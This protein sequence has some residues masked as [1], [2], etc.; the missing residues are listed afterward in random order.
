MGRPIKYSTTKLTG[1]LKKGN[2]I[3][4]MDKDN[5]DL[6][7][8]NSISP[9]HGYYVVYEAVPGGSPRMYVPQNASELIR[10][11]V[12]KGGVAVSTE[13]DALEWL[14]S[15]GYTTK[16]KNLDIN[17]TD[18]LVLYY[19]PSDVSSYP[20]K[21]S[22]IYDLSGNGNN[23]SLYNGITMSSGLI[24]LDG[25]NDYISIPFNSSMSGW[26]SGQTIL[27]WLK[28]NISSGRRNPWNQAYGGY[29]TWTHEQG[30][31][32][33]QY[34]GDAGANASPYIG[35]SSPT[36]P[37]NTWN[38]VA[39]TRDTLTHSW[40]LN[41]NLSSSRGHSYGVL[42][43][44]TNQVLIG[45]GYA[46]YW[47]GQMGPI[48]AYDRALTQDEIKSVWFNGNIVTDGLVLAIDPSSLGSYEQGS[49]TTN[50]L[51]NPLSGTLLNGMGYST[52]NGGTFVFD[53]I[54]DNIQVD[55]QS[56]LGTFSDWSVDAWVKWSDIGYKSWMIVTDQAQYSKFY[57]N[58]MVWLSSDSVNKRIA[59]YDGG[60]KYSVGNIPSNT[61]THIAA[62]TE[63]LVGKM[64]INGVLD[65]VNTFTWTDLTNTANYLGIGGHAGNSGYRFNGNIGPVRTYSRTLTDDEVMQNYNAQKYRFTN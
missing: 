34:F 51:V 57:K 48:T 31:N 59:M 26:N 15:N 61:W 32:I 33:S 30:G 56:I 28:H 11:A 54:N 24:N 1:T 6:T 35:V 49:L 27:M 58:T 17:I 37:K 23:G 45:N 60:W 7:W 25:I 42:T 3:V 63:G 13:A 39:T 4:G 9:T 41:G 64:Y 21:G 62:T 18:G 40:Y 8:Y 10:L 38:L 29:G 16:D 12:D 2:L 50:S 20:G 5:Y 47:Q 65:S 22:V 14:V 19:N 43:T 44:D 55:T 36:I 52:Q 53:G 46:G